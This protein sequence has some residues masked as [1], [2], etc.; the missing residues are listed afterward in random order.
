MSMYNDIDWSKGEHFK[1]CVE[2]YGSQG[3]RTQIPKGTL[4]SDQ[5]PKQSGMDSTR[6]SPKVSGTARHK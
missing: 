3:L 6:I 5:E 2:L 1:M 4:S